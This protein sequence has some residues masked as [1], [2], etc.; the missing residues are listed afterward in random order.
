[1][2]GDF[3]IDRQDGSLEEFAA[4]VSAEKDYQEDENIQKNIYSFL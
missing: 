3:I 4:L 1:V 2:L